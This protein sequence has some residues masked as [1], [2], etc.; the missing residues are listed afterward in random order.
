MVVGGD[1]DMSAIYEAHQH[2]SSG[3]THLLVLDGQALPFKTGSFD[4]VISL[5]TVE[6]LRR[7]EEFLA[8]CKRVLRPGGLFICS[9]P[10]MDGHFFLTKLV[11]THGF[12]LSVVEKVPPLYRIM[13]NPF[14]LREFSQ[15]EFRAF[16]EK[17]FAGV[18]V[19][20]HRWGLQKLP[21]FSRLPIVGR[22]ILEVYKFLAF[23][24]RLL[25]RPPLV[26]LSQVAEWEEFLKDFP[27]PFPLATRGPYCD[28][29]V[30]VAQAH[31]S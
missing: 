21:R 3:Q 4:A 22:G 19:Y 20:G 29:F 11:L 13:I 18:A 2:C 31:G 28:G 26:S 24:K 10:N 27:R 17:F 16:L 15:Q 5:E 14:H 8:E 9:T 23:V 30:A 25:I 6:H 1:I 7:P 12:L